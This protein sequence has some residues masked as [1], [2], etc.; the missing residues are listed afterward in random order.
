MHALV[1][2]ARSPSADYRTPG[3]AVAVLSAHLDWFT[4][5]QLLDALQALG[6]LGGAGPGPGAG[7]HS[8]ANSS[9]S[10]GAAAAAANAPGLSSTS[11]T[12]AN[13]AAAM[14]ASQPQQ[15]PQPPRQQPPP[16]VEALTNSG[17]ARTLRKASSLPDDLQDY[18][19]AVYPSMG[20]ACDEDPNLDL[21]SRIGLR[22]SRGL[23]AQTPAQQA[24]TLAQLGL[25]LGRHG[26]GQGR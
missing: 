14:G 18:L 21:L 26:G 1:L 11:G 20:P 8:S 5:G 16:W 15:P 24:R 23:A 2:L 19:G 12:F 13:V 10:G 6:R 4:D 9:M 3:K 22:L 7:Q 25:G 17:A